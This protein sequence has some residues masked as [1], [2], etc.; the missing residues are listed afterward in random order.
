MIP[1]WD[2]TDLM[3]ACIKRDVAK[4]EKLL[5]QNPKLEEMANT[6]DTALLFAAYAGSVKIAQMLINAGAKITA[7]NHFGLNI[8]H[9]AAAHG[10]CDMIRFILDNKYFDVNCPG[11]LGEKVTQENHVI[12]E[13]EKECP[14][15]LHLS[16]RNG[17]VQT[18]KLLLEYGAN[19]NA[20]D[21]NGES[22]LIYAVREQH[23]DM[24]DFLIS[25]GADVNQADKKGY[26]AAF[27][28]MM[29]MDISVYNFDYVKRIAKSMSIF[30]ALRKA[31]AIMGDDVLRATSLKGSAT[32]GLLQELL[33]SRTYSQDTLNE[34]LVNACS[35]NEAY[36]EPQKNIQLLMR[37][38]AMPVDKVKDM[39]FNALQISVI[40]SAIKNM[41][42]LVNA[43]ANLNVMD[44][45]R[46][47]LVN[48]A[49][50]KH[51]LRILR[52]LVSEYH[53]PCNIANAK[54][55]TPL[56]S[57]V[58][59]QRHYNPSRVSA[60]KRVR[61]QPSQQNWTNRPAYCLQEKKQGSG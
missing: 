2:T 37:H 26:A 28:G 18:A 12:I 43:G 46:N 21:I 33:E 30:E 15:P 35:C 9:V 27:R 32:R 41:R 7:C 5:A 1:L 39:P 60:C 58:K 31:G 47:T 54:G 34:A 61:C 44:S 6:G 49:A 45:S 48:L 11:R 40:F 59:K 22:P 42:Q 4:V 50:C 29:A 51:D 55:D 38:G 16:A 17:H 8:L 19:I 36:F 56:L 13:Y 10:Q 57:A 14:T 3:D 53:L 23:A 52:I 24:V 25:E 20:T